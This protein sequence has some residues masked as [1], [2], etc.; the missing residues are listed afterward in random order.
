MEEEKK[1]TLNV[2]SSFFKHG[3]KK[4]ES[5]VDT[6]SGCDVDTT[7][8]C[9]T[10]GS[11]ACVDDTASSIKTTNTL[12]DDEE[13]DEWILLLD[14]SRAN[15]QQISIFLIVLGIALICFNYF[16]V[17]FTIFGKEGGAI[18][19]RTLNLGAAFVIIVTGLIVREN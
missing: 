17:V 11:I 14:E 8:A 15:V 10:T 16:D 7:I 18:I 19:S 3:N 6:T 5:C 9:D 1:T 13:E 12:E 4:Q 2:I